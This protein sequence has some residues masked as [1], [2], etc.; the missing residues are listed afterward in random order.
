MRTKAL[1]NG[2]PGFCFTAKST[3]RHWSMQMSNGTVE[4]ADIGSPALTPH[5][6]SGFLPSQPNYHLSPTKANLR[7]QGN[8][9]G[10][11]QNRQRMSLAVIRKFQGTSTQPQEYFCCQG[12]GKNLQA[13]ATY[14]KVEAGQVA[15]W[16]LVLESKWGKKGRKQKQNP[17]PD[18]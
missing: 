18:F 4:L 10:R 2:G 11:K 1:S 14:P 3:T 15:S 5:S 8:R 12:R 6:C 16:P 9:K 7:R 17:E 13:Q